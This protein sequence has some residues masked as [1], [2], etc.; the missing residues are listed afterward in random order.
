MYMLVKLRDYIISYLLTLTLYSNYIL[1]DLNTSVQR[2]MPASAR[3]CD[4]RI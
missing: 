3:Y 4:F 2:G 1:T